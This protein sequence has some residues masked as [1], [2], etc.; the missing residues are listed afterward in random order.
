MQPEYGCN[1]SDYQ[2][3]PM[4]NTLVGLIRDVVRDAILYHEPRI[5][6]DNIT[7]SESDSQDAIEGVLLISI[8]Y[9][10]RETN[11]RFNFVYDFYLKEGI[12]G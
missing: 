5:R 12:G 9:V 4:N 8:D 2:F 11:S 7:V 10:I 6:V 3:E 1:L